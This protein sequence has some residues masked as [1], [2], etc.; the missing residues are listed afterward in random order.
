[1]MKMV[2]IAIAFLLVSASPAWAGEI[3]GTCLLRFVGIST[4]HDFSGTVRC[5]PFSAGL[6]N[7]AEGGTTV[8]AVEVDILVDEMDTEDE[9]RDGQM[10]EMFQSDKFPRIH[11]SVREIDVDGIR[12]EIGNEGGGK[13]FF[14]L[15]LRVRDTE[16][17]IQATV[18]NLREEGDRVG[19][20][21]EFPVSLKDFGL[22]AP[23]FLVIF[24]VRDKV[25]VTGN[26]LL[27]VSSKE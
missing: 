18:T 23:S 17:T 12:R 3:K 27:E 15:T 7:S 8:P 21:V 22:K 13:A 4:L 2:R 11:G 26:V 19:F 20:D 1:M 5:Q 24:R 16:R 6:V 9:S 14:D 25:T 10:R